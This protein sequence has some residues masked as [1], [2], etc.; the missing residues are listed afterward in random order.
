M[1]RMQ[2]GAFASIFFGAV[3]MPGVPIEVPK[4]ILLDTRQPQGLD[5][6]VN[7]REVN[8]MDLRDC[9]LRKVT[10]LKQVDMV[11]I[12]ENTEGP[13]NDVGGHFAR[14]T[15]RQVSIGTII[16][17]RFGV[18]R[19]LR[20]AFE[21]AMQ[22]R[23]KL[24]IVDKSNAM[25]FAHS[26]YR[27]IGKELQ[28]EYPEVEVTFMYFDIAALELAYQPW[29]FDVVVG[30]NL[31]GDVLSDLTAGLFGG[32]GVAP[33]QNINPEKKIGLFEPVHGSW[34]IKAGKDE[35]NPIG[36]VLTAAKMLRFLGRHSDADRI[37]AAVRVCRRRN[38]VTRDMVGG[39]LG[40][41][42]AGDAIISA[43]AA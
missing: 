32:M 33:S 42:A 20:Y 13:Y 11:V 15:D 39:T 1:T 5:L 2:A 37:E 40:T 25:P 22:R 6:Y 31:I 30:D 21:R 4:G 14:G 10:R 41:R 26:L 12:R 34:P 43:L 19:I 3:G 23:K 17:T 35:A 7:E 16:T 36:S 28:Q 27:E 8:L 29:N 18:E 24:C 38:L 9:P